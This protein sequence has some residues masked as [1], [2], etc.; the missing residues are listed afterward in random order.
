MVEPDFNGYL[1]RAERGFV[2]FGS[3]VLLL[4]LPIAA[5]MDNPMVAL[6]GFGILSGTL[7][8]SLASA[9]ERLPKTKE[10]KLPLSSLE[11]TLDTDLGLYFSKLFKR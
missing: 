11:R 2:Q 10:S 7:A 4:S 5:F 3:Y 9:N 1:S 6:E 8:Y